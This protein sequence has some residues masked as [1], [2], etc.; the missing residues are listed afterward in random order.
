MRTDDFR[1]NA[2]VRSILVRKWIDTTKCSIGT[3]KGKVYIRGRISRIFGRSGRRLDEED[4][5]KQ[6]PSRSETNELTLIM[7]IE[8][9][10]RRIPDV[11]DIHF[12]L[13]FWVKEKGIWKRRF[14]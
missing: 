13:E 5:D 8:D 6:D 1:I 10:V 9:E 7:Q 14:I 3:I 12:D 2:R 11:V 4:S